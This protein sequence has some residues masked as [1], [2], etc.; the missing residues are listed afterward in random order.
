MFLD[1]FSSVAN[2]ETESLDAALDEHVE[3]VFEYRTIGGWK[4]RLRPVRS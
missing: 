3:D 1:A 4:H 2:D